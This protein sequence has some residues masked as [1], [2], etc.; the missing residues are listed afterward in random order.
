VELIDSVSLVEDT[1]ILQDEGIESSLYTIEDQVR[2]M[3]FPLDGKTYDA[4]ELLAVV[5]WPDQL[6]EITVGNDETPSAYAITDATATSGNFFASASACAARTLLLIKRMEIDAEYFD[7]IFLEQEADGS[8][9]VAD[10]LSFDGSQGQSDTQLD[11]VTEAIGTDKTCYAL[12]VTSSTEGGDINLHRDTWVEYYIS[13]KHAFHSVLKIVLEET[14]VQDYD[15][16]QDENKDSTSEI[17]E[18]EF[19]KTTSNGLYDVQIHT[20]V[21]QNGTIISKTDDIFRF[22]GVI[23]ARP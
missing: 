2:Q 8:P 20:T 4:Q 19:L 10:K 14:D 16:S 12:K 21:K 1:V 22:N 3:T 15:G 17:R 5:Y 11:I 18:Y 7:L 13:D 6:G 9:K 23:Y